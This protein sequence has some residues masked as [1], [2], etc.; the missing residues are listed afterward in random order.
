MNGISAEG[1]R[2]ALLADIHG[3]RLALDAVLEDIERRG[4]T[5]EYWVLGDLVALGPQP[6]EVLERLQELEKAVFVRGNTDRYVTTGE[7]PGPTAEE[8]QADPALLPVYAEIAGSFGWTQG[9]VASG[10]WLPFLDALPLEHDCVLPDGTH[11]LA[12]HASPGSDDEPGV[13]PD[14]PPDALQQ[15]FDGCAADLVVVGHTHWPTD[16]RVGQIQAINP[17]SVSNP[18]VP[19][20]GA[21][22]AILEVT[23][24]SYRVERYRVEYDRDAVIGLLHEVR[25][26]G[27]TFIARYFRGELIRKGWGMPEV[28]A[29]S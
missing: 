27:R 13:R 16:I 2:I 11:A 3:N 6:V 29:G 1:V 20:L 18:V 28:E 10:G 15:L 5:D 19:G 7:R 8:V 25:H 14:L 17:G 4:G 23:P 21:S 9:A 12:V 26:P 22:Y 24:R